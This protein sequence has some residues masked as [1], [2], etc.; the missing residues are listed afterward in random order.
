MTVGINKNISY[1]FYINTEQGENVW[2]HDLNKWRDALKDFIEF[3]DTEG[4]FFEI[5]I[6]DEEG[7]GYVEIYPTDETHLLPK[8]V[9]KYVHK[10]LKAKEA[11]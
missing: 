10:L 5:Q 4:F 1:E 3:K 7:C 6:T 8:Y 11:A 2:H 9:Q